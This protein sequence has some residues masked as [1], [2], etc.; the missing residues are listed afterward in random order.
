MTIL[1]YFVI[2][3]SL[4]LFV[5]SHATASQSSD[6]GTCY[7]AFSVSV[8]IENLGISRAAKD[9]LISHGLVFLGD[10]ITN[11]NILKIPFFQKSK[12]LS[13][14]TAA[15]ERR[16][17][18]LGMKVRGWQLSVFV[19]P[20]DY[21][22]SERHGSS[23]THSRIALYKEKLRDEG[24]VYIGDLVRRQKADLLKVHGIGVVFANEI[25]YELSIMGRGLHF[26]MEIHEWS[27]SP[28][29][30]NQLMKQLQLEEL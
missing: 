9:I 12:N 16:G 13:E 18:H 21:R 29:R 6:R 11:P 15:L 27:P 3:V 4:K 26:G 5:T 22:L 23:V 17:L 30:F 25:E 8:S 20:I 7:T 24:I 10:V 1:T 2:L 28:E 14:L 19:L